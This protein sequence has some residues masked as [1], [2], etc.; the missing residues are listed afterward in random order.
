MS[1]EPRLKTLSER[2]ESAHER[3][4]QAREDIN[5]MVGLR[6]GM[7][8]AGIPADA[9]TID[10]LQ[11]GRR[12]LLVLHDHQPEHVLYQ[13]T[14]LERE[15]EDDWEQLPFSAATTEQLFDWMVE[16]FSDSER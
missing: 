1:E 2:T 16:Y 13:F 5:P 12:I 10:C 6:S 15:M 9:L 7:R 11:T 4:Q 14:T 8:Q 3:V